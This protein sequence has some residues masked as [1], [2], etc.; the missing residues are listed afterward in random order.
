[1]SRPPYPHTSESTGREQTGDLDHLD[2]LPLEY[3]DL[4][5]LQEE[6]A[7]TRLG[8]PRPQTEGEVEEADFARTFMELSA[9]VGHVLSVYQRQYAGEAYISTA[10]APSSLVRHAHRLA[11]DPDPGLAASG[12]V[13]VFAKELVSGTVAAGLPLASVPL[14]EIKAQDY[15][16]RDDLVVDA[17]LNELVP[18]ARAAAGGD[19]RRRDRAPPRRASAT[20]SRPAT[21]SRSSGRSGAASSSRRRSRMP[22][23]ARRPFASTAPSAPRS[24]SLRPIRRRRCSRIRRSRCGRSVPSADPALFPPA[25]GQGRDGNQADAVPEVLVRRPARRRGGLQRRRRLPLRAGRPIRSPAGTSCARRAPPSPCCEV[26]AEVVAAVTINREV[27][28]SFTTQTV[29]LTPT[30]GGGFTTTLTPA[31]GTQTV[32]G[33]VS[34]TVTAIRVANQD[35]ESVLRSAQPFPAEWLADWAVEAA[36]AASEPNPAPASSSR[37]SSPACCRRSLR[38]ATRLQ[39]PRRDGGAGRGD[40]PRR[41]GRRCGRDPHLV[42]SGDRAAGHR[43]DASTT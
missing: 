1:M 42:G 37:W 31:T 20:G 8:R 17:A 18:L 16:T 32:A 40:P 39:R 5:A 11:Y 19:R 26:T 6:L 9:L 14:G 41:A 23:E 43:L 22:G 3:A 7:V 25:V 27:Q 24:T 30:A 10:Q 33:H 34:G 36:L 2:Y 4:L 29:T 21:G 13:V 15:E 12:Y 38:A 35:G 28:E